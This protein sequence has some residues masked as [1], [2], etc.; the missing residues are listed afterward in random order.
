MAA[1]PLLTRRGKIMFVGVGIGAIGGYLFKHGGAKGAIIGSVIGGI[2]FYLLGGYT[3]MSDQAA[4]TA[5]FSSANSVNNISI[6]TMP[7]KSVTNNNGVV[8]GAPIKLA[9]GTIISV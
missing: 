3:G 6:A 4:E 8:G 5:I 1:T 2:L 9:N 7:V